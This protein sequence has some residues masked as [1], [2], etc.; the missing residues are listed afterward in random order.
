MFTQEKIKA[1]RAFVKKVKK[2]IDTYPLRYRNPSYMMQ[3]TIQ[4]LVHA[5]EI[6]HSIEELDCLSAQTQEVFY[7]QSP[8]NFCQFPVKDDEKR[9]IIYRPCR[10]LNSECTHLVELYDLVYIP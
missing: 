3:Q 9:F 2:F 7:A 1:S 5:V 10:Y 4:D 8:E 6:S